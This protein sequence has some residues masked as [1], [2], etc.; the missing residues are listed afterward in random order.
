MRRQNGG[1]PTVLFYDLFGRKNRKFNIKFRPNITAPDGA[2]KWQ[3]PTKKTTLYHLCQGYMNAMR[4]WQRG[5]F[6][7]TAKNVSTKNCGFLLFFGR[8]LQSLSTTKSNSTPI[9]AL[10][11]KGRREFLPKAHKG[12]CA[13]IFLRLCRPLH[14]NAKVNKR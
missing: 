4:P 9:R 8:V 1:F 14:C 10:L 6:F 7:A 12:L 5:L 13:K 3:P 2:G 11:R